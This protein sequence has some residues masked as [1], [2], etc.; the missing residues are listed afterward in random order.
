L[1]LI[2]ILKALLRAVGY[3]LCAVILAGLFGQLVRDRSV[4]TAILMYLPVLPVSAGTIGIDLLLRG[5]GLNRP[6][7][8]LT[9]VGIFGALFAAIPMVGSGAGSA[10]RAGE[11]EVTLLHWNVYWGGG[12]SRSDLRWSEQRTE[13]LK[14]SPDLI[15]LSE[16]PPSYWVE[17]RGDEKSP[18][19]NVVGIE[20]DAH[21]PY[22]YS[23]AV[24]SRWP[25]RLETR[26]PLPGG[27]AMSVTVA[28][29][30]RP[31]RFLV[32]DGKSNP[33]YSRLPFLHAIAEI[34][35][36]AER[37]GRPFAAVV[38]D[39]NTPSRSI[40]FDELANQG[41][42]LAGRNA[43]GWRGTF[44][45]FMPIYDIDH[46]WVGPNIILLSCKFFTGPYSDHRGQF[47]TVRPADGAATSAAAGR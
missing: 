24:C 43:A 17:R 18:I 39:F 27:V 41:F 12:M 5:R 3:G 44:P 2:I 9:V 30:G 23:V 22:W 31:F 13:I 25:I 11:Q 37:E 33:F 4:A 15:I 32:V 6:R 7:F 19:A 40:G 34:C 20:H 42:K 38:G 47:V 8:M 1:Y 46:V 36:A 28:V 10:E 26:A 21:S 35:Q 16:L 14:H 29:R 45:A